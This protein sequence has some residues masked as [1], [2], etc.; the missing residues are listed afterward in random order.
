MARTP[1][2][3]PPEVELAPPPGFAQALTDV[4]HDIEALAARLV[5][6]IRN[7]VPFYEH[8]PA[9]ALLAGVLGDAQR[10]LRAVQERRDA[11]TEEL[12]EAG[13]VGE[14]RASQGVPVEAV[15]QAFQ[16]GVEEICEAVLARGREL[17]VSDAQLLGVH[18]RAWAWANRVMTHQA[19]EHRRAEL[20]AVRRDEARRGA[21]V[22]ELL[23]GTTTVSERPLHST[24][25]GFP[26]TPAHAMRARGTPPTLQSLQRDLEQQALGVFTL[27]DEDL[28]GI[29]ARPPRTVP[30]NV[31]IGLGPQADLSDLAG[32]FAAATRAVIAASK[33]KRP[34]PHTLLSLGLLPAVT[35][36]RQIG[37]RLASRHLESL[38]GTPIPE[39]LRVLLN[40]DLRVEDAARALFVHPNT[41]RKRIARYEE[42][43]GARLRRVDD[44]VE[45]WWALRWTES[46]SSASPE[47]G[48]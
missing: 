3:G 10:G 41:V 34:G 23:S 14:A 45:L 43:T 25:R 24:M 30:D 7:E 20:E 22:R 35:D 4:E 37:E 39:T 13:D 33:F 28:V 11:T 38:S 29:I 6:R 2:F 36:E 31:T 5:E 18:Q 40:M 46:S 16:L 1:Q 19:R 27:Q 32:S 9:E 15:V 26:D 8:V 17:G 12:R 47:Q 48:L 21:F 42:A 44:L